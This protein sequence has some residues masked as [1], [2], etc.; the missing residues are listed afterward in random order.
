[1]EVVSNLVTLLHGDGKENRLPQPESALLLIDRIDHPGPDPTNTSSPFDTPCANPATLVLTDKTV[2]RGTVTEARE[3]I[4][5]RAERPKMTPLTTMGG[6]LLGRRS[7]SP[8]N[9]FSG[10]T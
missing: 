5:F 8:M 9:Q 10:D 6:T 4:V 2:I 7:C 3:D 1:L